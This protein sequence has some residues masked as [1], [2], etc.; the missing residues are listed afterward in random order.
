M[1]ALHSLFRH[2]DHWVQLIGPD[3]VG[4]GLDFVS[5]LE[6]LQAFVSARAS[7][8]PAG[9]GYDEE[10]RFALPEQLPAL[11]ERMLQADYDDDHVRGI[12]GGNWLRV[13]R[14]VWT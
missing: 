8:F 14:A 5:D 12:L 13:A 7:K 4:I 10:P 3:H 11:T 1:G 6:V 9:Q 2:L